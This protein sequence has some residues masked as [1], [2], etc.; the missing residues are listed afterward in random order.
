[1]GTRRLLV[2]RCAV[3]TMFPYS[4]SIL[5]IFSMPNKTRPGGDLL[6]G[7]PVPVLVRRVGLQTTKPRAVHYA[8]LLAPRP[9]RTLLFEQG[10]SLGSGVPAV[11]GAQIGVH[12]WTMARRGVWKRL[13]QGGAVTG[14]VDF[15]IFMVFQMRTECFE[16]FGYC[17]RFA[18]SYQS[19]VVMF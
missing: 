10:W 9:P 1:M 3:C 4:F 13:G 15:M 6:A 11:P 14:A 18:P 17:G 8:V 19:N 16:I 12:Q 7:N 2:K 5:Y